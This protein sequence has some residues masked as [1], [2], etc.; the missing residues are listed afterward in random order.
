[1][2][3]GSTASNGTECAQ[4]AHLLYKIIAAR[5][6]KRS[7]AL[8]AGGNGMNPGRRRHLSLTQ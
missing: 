6:Q 1:M 7:T 5:S 8:V 2:N 3:S 4:A